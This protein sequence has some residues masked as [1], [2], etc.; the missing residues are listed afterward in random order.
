MHCTAK[1][2]PNEYRHALIHGR[3]GWY[4]VDLGYLRA[5]RLRILVRGMSGYRSI[6][7]LS[8]PEMCTPPHSLDNMTTREL[9]H[10]IHVSSSFDATG[11]LYILHVKNRPI[12]RK[13]TPANLG[14]EDYLRLSS[15]RD[16][17]PMTESSPCK[18]RS[19]D[20]VVCVVMDYMTDNTG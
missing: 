5:Y 11:D 18:R 17:H 9:S 12:R 15:V 4:I 1:R 10:I 7:S 13:T 2:H 20:T 3:T 6:C 19:V 14:L 8:R 16:R